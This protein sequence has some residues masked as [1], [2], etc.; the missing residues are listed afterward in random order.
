MRLSCGNILKPPQGARTLPREPA[1]LGAGHIK[2]FRRSYVVHGQDRD[3]SRLESP[4]L[5]AHRRK[6]LNPFKREP[7]RLNSKLPCRCS[8]FVFIHSTR[9]IVAQF[10]APL[11]LAA[12]QVPR[13][14]KLTAGPAVLHYGGRRAA[15]DRLG[16]QAHGGIRRGSCYSALLD[17]WTAAIILPGRGNSATPEPPFHD[18]TAALSGEDRGGRKPRLTRSSR[19]VV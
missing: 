2:R 8:L 18:V 15:P 9:P 14:R 7:G 11:D 10:L 13:S 6:I 16:T 1:P 12:D 17:S 19:K 4:N 3:E 5:V